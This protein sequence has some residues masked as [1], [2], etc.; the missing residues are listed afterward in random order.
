MDS[1]RVWSKSPG[2]NFYPVSRS[3]S[4]ATS[5]VQSSQILTT[6]SLIALLHLQPWS[7]LW[8]LPCCSHPLLLLFWF[9]IYPS[10]PNRLSSVRLRGRLPATTPML[11][12][13][14]SACG[15]DADEICIHVSQCQ[16]RMLLGQT[17]SLLL[18]EYRNIGSSSIRTRIHF[19]WWKGG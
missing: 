1:L 16:F 15:Q 8:A 11:N 5:S 12:R 7:T 10:C 13:Q 9:S 4:D 3:S 2:T 18:W 14:Y 19:P 6:Q 17:S